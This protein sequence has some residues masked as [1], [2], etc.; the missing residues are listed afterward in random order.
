MLGDV[1]TRSLHFGQ[2][3]CGD[4]VEKG[5]TRE[6]QRCGWRLVGCGGR[7]ESVQTQS[8]GFL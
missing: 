2:D 5:A 6:E 1:C 7:E 4:G 3:V 8:Q